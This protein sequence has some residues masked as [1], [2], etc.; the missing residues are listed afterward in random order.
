MNSVRLKSIKMHPKK[1]S[2]LAG[3]GFLMFAAVTSAQADP[4]LFSNVVALQNGGSTQVDLFSN[5]GVTLIGPQIS[6]LVDIGGVLPPI[7][8]DLLQI[9]FIE[10]GQLPVVQTIRIPLFDGLSLPYTQIFSFTFQNPTLSGTGATLQLDILG[11]SPD[12][13]IP[14]SGQRVDTFTYTFNGAEAVPEPGTMAML[15]IGAAGLLGGARRKRQRESKEFE[16]RES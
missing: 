5:P 4:L 11:S 2:I 6:F 3:L 16:K 12:F 14:S 8:S 15:V 7:G 10:A 9:T 13:V 1:T